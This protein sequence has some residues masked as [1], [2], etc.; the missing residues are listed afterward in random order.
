MGEG[1]MSLLKRLFRTSSKTVKKEETIDVQKVQEFI[2]D[3][4]IVDVEVMV[5]E[6]PKVEISFESYEGGPS[7]IVTHSTDRLII[8][9]KREYKKPVFFWMDFPKCILKV[10]VPSDIADHWD[11]KATSGILTA[12]NLIASE[13]H[14]SATSGK[15]NL[16]QITANKVILTTTSGKIIVSEVKAEKLTF[17]ANSGKAEISSVYG[18]IN[19]KVGSGGIRLAEVKGEV[20][21]LKAGSGIISLKEVYMKNATLQ[22]NSGKIE[23]ENYWVETTD[24]SVGSGK[25][26]IR[27]YRGAIKGSANSGNINISISDNSNLDLRTG[28][29]NIHLEF[30]EFELNTKYDI[31]TGSGEIITNLPMTINRGEKHH[32]QGLSGNGEYLIRLRTGSGRTVL[33]TA[34]SSLIKHGK[35]NKIS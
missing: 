32:L 25:I 31:K 14:V 2:I 20:L 18:D 30:H 16:K 35:G 3:V 28:S 24:A 7:L 33:Y 15:I 34:K 9:A 1:W 23:A 6:H 8:Q 13:I 21:Q 29:G 12:A 11:M 4:D 17:I 27:D 19:G 26:N 22:A 5:H 10:F